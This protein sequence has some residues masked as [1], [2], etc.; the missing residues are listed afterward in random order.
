[1]MMPPSQPGMNPTQGNPA[2]VPPQEYQGE[3]QQQD[4]QIEHPVMIPPPPP[5]MI[6]PA[7][8]PPQG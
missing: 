3:M 1:M 6:I 8:L 5:G 7:S 4:V 2:M